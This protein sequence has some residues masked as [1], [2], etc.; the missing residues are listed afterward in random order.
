MCIIMVS[1]VSG[2][3]VLVASSMNAGAEVTSPVAKTLKER[4]ALVHLVSYGAATSVF[5]QFGLPPDSIIEKSG[6][7]RDEISTHL[8]SEVKRILGEFNP[9]VVLT[10]TQLQDADHRITLEQILWFSGR[11]SV[12]VTDTWIN[13]N[14]RFSD[15]VPGSNRE[16]VPGTTRK[17]LPNV[18][19]A[20]DRFAFDQMVALGFDPSTLAVTGN[21]YFEHVLT[22]GA[23]FSDSDKQA[24]VEKPVFSSFTKGATLVVFLSDSIETA[25]PD[26]GFTEKSVLASFIQGVVSL[27][28]PI[29]VVV[30]PHPF[31]GANAKDAFDSSVP[32]SSKAKFVLHNPASAR[33][34]DPAN[35]YPIELLLAA[36]DVVVGTINNPLITAAILRSSGNSPTVIQYTPGISDAKYRFYAFLADRGITSEALNE[37]DLARMLNSTL[38]G[39][40]R[41]A[42]FAPSVGAIDRVIDLL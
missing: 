28:C 18:I 7:N 11:R 24:L 21:P 20:I 5:K 13:Y 16:I 15:L 10:G 29:N 22:V 1:N 27:D 3:R 2:K 41:Q 37:F 34:S 35:D 14:E 9:D 4:G 32:S 40:L 6:S 26:I 33:G 39:S 30:R 12:A 17:Y 31:R 25:Y 42:N 36:A 38:N 8:N 19:T 23:G